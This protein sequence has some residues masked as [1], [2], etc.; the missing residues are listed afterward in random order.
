M[1]ITNKVFIKIINGA[2]I[3]MKIKKHLIPFFVLLIFYA[4]NENQ[5]TLPDDTYRLSDELRVVSPESQSIDPQIFTNAYRHADTISGLRSFIVIRNGYIVGE[6]YY[7]SVTVDSIDYI[8]SV[9]KSVVSILIGIAIDKGFIL[10]DQQQL[11]DIFNIDSMGIDEAKGRIKI[12]H[13]LTM[14]S[15]LEWDEW[16][17]D[18]RGSLLSGNILNYVLNKDLVAEPGTVFNY[19]TGSTHILSV[20][21]TATTGMN[22]LEFANK[23]LFNFLGINNLYWWDDDH[24]NSIGG[25][26]LMMRPRDMA[27][28]GILFLNKGI[29]PDRCVSENWISKSTS[30]EIVLNYSFAG[31]VFNYGYL[32]FN[33]M[34][35]GYDFYTAWGKTGSFIFCIPELNMVAVTQSNIALNPIVSDKQEAD[36]L[37]LIVNYLLPAVQK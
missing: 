29:T 37:D 18:I 7:G 25:H 17:G 9:T 3:I 8:H 27:K 35:S 23:Y 13:L 34:V 28:I 32:W 4:C 16:G 24:G 22:A 19:S 15:G 30:L 36:N 11:S 10:D 31:V 2:I 1:K 12:S 5:I 26:G 33:G 21:I 6:E 14:T 20:I